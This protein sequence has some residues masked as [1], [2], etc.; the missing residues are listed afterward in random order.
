ML[1]LNLSIVKQLQ[2]SQS[3][4]VAVVNYAEVANVAAVAPQPLY[5]TIFGVQANFRVSYMY[6]NHVITRVKCIVI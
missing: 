4:L 1:Q 3:P 5:N 2:L 6:P